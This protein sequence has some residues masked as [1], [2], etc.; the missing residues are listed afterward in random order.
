MYDVIGRRRKRKLWERS[1]LEG[2]ARFSQVSDRFERGLFCCFCC[3]I[4]MAFGVL[5]EDIRCKFFC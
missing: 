5:I 4:Y 2:A 1:C 3:G